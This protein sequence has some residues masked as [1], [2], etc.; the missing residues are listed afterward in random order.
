MKDATG[1][2]RT[3]LYNTLNNSISYNGTWITC[4][5]FPSKDKQPPYIL[6]AEI[7]MMGEGESTKDKWITEYQA[8]VEIYTLSTGNRASYAAVDSISD[9]ILNQIRGSVKQPVDTTFTGSGGQSVAG[10]TGFNL[11]SNTVVGIASQRF[12]NEKGIIIMKSITF[13]LILEES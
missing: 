1:N 3:W 12:E 4:D 2:I 5:S 7:D 10:I 6:I 11:I 8:I 13:K 9:D